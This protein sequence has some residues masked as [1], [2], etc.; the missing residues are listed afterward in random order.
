MPA[1]GAGFSVLPP[2]F[3]QPGGDMAS[4]YAPRIGLV[5]GSYISPFDSGGKTPGNQR[6]QASSTA[7]AEFEAMYG[8]GSRAADEDA[9]SEGSVNSNGTVFHKPAAGPTISFGQMSPV[10]VRDNDKDRAASVAAK[11]V[12][13]RPSEGAIPRQ[14]FLG[15][16]QLVRK[17]CAD[18]ITSN[19]GLKLLG[20]WLQEKMPQAFETVVDSDEVIPEV[21]IS[22]SIPMTQENWQ[23]YN[24]VLPHF[25]DALDMHNALTCGSDEFD[26]VTKTHVEIAGIGTY[27][28]KEPQL[29]Q[30]L[31]VIP[32]LNLEEV[33]AGMVKRE[34]LGRPWDWGRSTYRPEL[35]PEELGGELKGYPEEG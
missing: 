28:H 8:P 22:V 32:N 27:Q 11:K 5:K 34:Q 1:V 21:I 15:P 14:L 24:E 31:L 29:T 6:L 26:Q 17:A 30:S 10:A 13:A 23:N 2:G 18:N 4:K 35:L 7:I 16:L 12:P 33:L 9:Q 20:E 25:K 19:E 3:S